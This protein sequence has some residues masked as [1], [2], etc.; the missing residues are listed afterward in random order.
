MA[1]TDTCDIPA[2]VEAVRVTDTHNTPAIVKADTQVTPPRYL[3]LLMLQTQVTCLSSK[4]C[5][6]QQSGV[7]EWLRGQDPS[8]TMY[9]C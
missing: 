4:P 7:M 5:H 9:R 8:C 1:L 3:R 2:I 6:S